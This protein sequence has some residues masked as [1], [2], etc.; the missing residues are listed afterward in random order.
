[1][2]SVFLIPVNIYDSFL[3][4][5]NNV[6]YYILIRKQL[7]IYQRNADKNIQIETKSSFPFFVYYIFQT[8]K[9]FWRLLHSI[10]SEI[11][12]FICSKTVEYK[13]KYMLF[14]TFKVR[15]NKQV[16]SRGNRLE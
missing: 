4:K 5:K 15:R 8:Q 16:E 9:Q 12:H 2:A 13:E 1:M 7:R 11:K 6:L 14:K 3:E 10:P